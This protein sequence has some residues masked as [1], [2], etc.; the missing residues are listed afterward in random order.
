MTTCP[1]S[2]TDAP[3][4]AL[5]YARSSIGRPVGPDGLPSYTAR[6]RLVYDVRFENAG[7]PLT[8]PG[9]PGSFSSPW[10]ALAV[11]V[12]EVQSVVTSGR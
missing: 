10:Q 11:P 9:C 4:C 1:C 12:A 8:L 3:T 7:A 6:M 2:T 5:T